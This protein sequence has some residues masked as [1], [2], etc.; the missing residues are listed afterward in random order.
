MSFQRVR[1]TFLKKAMTM[2][3]SLTAEKIT[4]RHSPRFKQ[5][6]KNMFSAR[7]TDF[8]AVKARRL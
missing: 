5:T 4:T 1:V 2:Q 7:N 6:E 8:S 3:C